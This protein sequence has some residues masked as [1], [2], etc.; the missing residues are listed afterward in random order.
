MVISRKGI[1]S[2]QLS[3][4]IGVSQPTAWYILQRLRIVCAAN[5]VLL[6]GIVEIDETYVGG[7][8]DNKHECK[9]LHSKHSEGKI[10]V[11]GLRERGGNTIA[12]PIATRD[13]R[14]LKKEIIGRIIP[15]STV[16]TDEHKGYL[17]V[18][19]SFNHGSV[20]HSAKEYVNG[21]IHTNGIESVWALLKRGYKG[22]YH[23]WSRKYMQLYANEFTFRLNEARCSV[24]TQDRINALFMRLPGNIIT[25]KSLAAYG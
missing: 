19:N 16:Y 6:K 14:T 3:H 23:H 7:K 25:L 18:K 20:N 13:N 11:L 24:D 1:S 21:N 5:G 9:K 15:G 2:L 10:C 4:E 22:I 17:W 8:E 12:I